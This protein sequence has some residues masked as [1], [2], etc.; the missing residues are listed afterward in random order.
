M[1]EFLSQGRAIDPVDHLFRRSLTLEDLDF[2]TPEHDM[3]LIG[4]RRYML[5]IDDY[6][7]ERKIQFKMDYYGLTEINHKLE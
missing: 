4:P 7:T 3:Y 1:V 6:L 5:M 2:I